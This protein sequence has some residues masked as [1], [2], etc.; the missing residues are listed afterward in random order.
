MADAAAA[1]LCQFPIEHRSN[2][3]PISFACR[4]CRKPAW[5]EIEQLREENDALRQKVQQL[6]KRK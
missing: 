4:V 3:E 5:K 2:G 6:E 1:H